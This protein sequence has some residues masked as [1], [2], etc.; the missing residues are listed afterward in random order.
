MVFAQMVLKIRPVIGMNI[1]TA[2]IAAAAN[3]P[4]SRIAPENVYIREF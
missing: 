1:V 2:D 3:Y 4:L